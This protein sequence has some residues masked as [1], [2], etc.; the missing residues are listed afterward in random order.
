MFERILEKRLRDY[1]IINPNQRGFIS[2]PGC[3]INITICEKALETAKHEKSDLVCLFL[4][5]NNAY[6]NIGH[7]QLSKSL[8]CSNTPE[9]LKNIIMDC[10]SENRI[11]LEIGHDKSSS[12][13]INKA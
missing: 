8:D 2:K 3:S 1:V 4:D 11:V 6:N 13:E 10:Q 5:I 7:T 9:F 12:I